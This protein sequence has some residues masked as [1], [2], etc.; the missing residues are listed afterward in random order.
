M[1]CVQRSDHARHREQRLRLR[2]PGD[3]LDARRVDQPE[4]GG[5]PGGNGVRTEAD[6]Q[7]P[8]GPADPRVQR[9]V[10]RV[11]AEPVP[12]EGREFGCVPEQREW[13]VV[14]DVH[15]R[16]AARIEDLAEL[17]AVEFL[18]VRVVRQ[19]D[20]VVGDGRAAERREVDREG[21][22]REGGEDGQRMRNREG[23][24]ARGCVLG[25]TRWVGG[26]VRRIGRG[27]HVAKR[28]PGELRAFARAIG[29]VARV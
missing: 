16:A 17:R 28:P 2:H 27:G 10:R 1:E 15:R 7:Q 3:G 14:R 29:W 9:D 13:R 8:E 23:G 5:R 12:A 6:E 25:A 22:Q 24:V 4:R 21:Q 20:D 11:V 26:G 19:V 18:D